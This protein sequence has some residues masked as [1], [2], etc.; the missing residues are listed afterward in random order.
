[1]GIFDGD[2][3]F[4]ERGIPDAT[5]VTHFRLVSFLYFFFYSFD[6]SDAFARFSKKNSVT[7]NACKAP[8]S[9]KAAPKIF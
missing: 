6:F 2:G 8:F 9:K 4:Y 7:K 3:G 1:V 5:A